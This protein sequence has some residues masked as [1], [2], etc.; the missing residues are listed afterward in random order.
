MPESGPTQ[1]A[2]RHAA[3]VNRWKS[4][5]LLARLVRVAIFIAPLASSVTFTWIA[6]IV[7]PPERLGVNRWVWIGLVFVAANGLLYVVSRL[8]RQLLPLVALMKLT[9]VFPDNAP[10]RTKATLRRSNSRTMLRQMEEARA[11]GETT[12]AA[13]HGDYLVQLLKEINEH[14]RLTRGHSERGP[15]L[16][17]DAR[18]GT[19]LRRERHE[20]ASLGGAA[21]RRREAVGPV[22]DP[23]Q[24]RPTDG[25]RMEGVVGPPGRRHPHARAAPA[26]ARRM[27]PRRRSTSLPLGRQGLSGDTGRHGDRGV[28][29]PGGDRRRLRR[30][31]QRS[32]LQAG[33]EPGSRPPGTHRLCG[34][35][36]RS[37]HGSCLPAHRARAV[38]DRGRTARLAGQPDRFGPDPDPGRLG[39]H[40]HGL[41][42]R[43]RRARRDGCEHHRSGPGRASTGGTARLRGPDDRRR[44]HAGHG[45]RGRD[46]RTDPDRRR[47]RRSSGV[48]V[49][50]RRPRH[51]H[52]GRR[53]H[54]RRRLDRPVAGTDRLSTRS[55]FRR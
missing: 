15:G 2:E 19:R 41:V 17:R 28:R 9:L 55:R 44:R 46:H 47:Q 43:G 12:G 52:P 40:E 48:L 45:N 54:A 32:Q 35:A 36:V 39:R 26:L 37:R 24:G 4:H 22:G 50:R 13:L 33:A 25:L 11:R 10:S 34:V 23:E 8:T 27:D 18:R 20:Q 7:L 16:R 14:D 1:G 42:R 29:P 38:E 30:H 21:A 6:G 49:R 5:P 3:T 53:G 31:D 51:G